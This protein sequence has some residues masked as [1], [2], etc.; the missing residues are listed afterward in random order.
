[1]SSND[2]LEIQE[3]NKRLARR[4]FEIFNVTRE[5]SQAGEVYAEDVANYDNGVFG[6]KGLKAMVNWG[7]LFADC[8]PDMQA[9]ITEQRAGDGFVVSHWE[10]SGT[11]T[12][13]LCGVDP[14]GAQL[15]LHGLYVDICRDGK[16]TE[17]WGYY[18]S[19]SFLQQ[20]G[21]IRIPESAG[22]LPEPA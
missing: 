22:H 14:H 20:V 16:I 6:F 17:H 4:G 11:I 12:G 3:S 19:A 15:V 5:L 8:V 1:M 9:R 18:D 21:A 10:S 13:K 7:K 2:E